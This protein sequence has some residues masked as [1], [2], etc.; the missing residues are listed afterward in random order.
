MS[1]RKV[2]IEDWDGDGGIRIPDEVLQ[3]LGVDVGDSL[4]FVEEY[5]GSTRCFVLSKTQRMNRPWFCRHSMTANG[6]R[7]M[8]GSE[9]I[10][11]RC[12][13]PKA[14]NPSSAHHRAC[15]R[16]RLDKTFRRD[17]KQT[18]QL[19]DHRQG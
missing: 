15:P 6:G 8:A 4:Y 16:N 14:Q 7:S 12:T 3:E 13:I 11:N 1:T 18:M 10:L 17:A 5:V 9:F 2:V 19:P